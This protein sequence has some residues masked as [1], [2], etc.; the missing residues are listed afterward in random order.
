VSLT[1]HYS[2]FNTRQTYQST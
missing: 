2:S 1:E